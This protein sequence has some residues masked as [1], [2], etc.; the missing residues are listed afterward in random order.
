MSPVPN[1]SKPPTPSEFAVIA[2]VLSGALITVGL[3]G[4]GF[5]LFA[6]P[7]KHEAAAT[8]IHL[9]GWAVGLGAFIGVAFWTVRRFTD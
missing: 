6:P 8:L 7:Q 3:I 1:L 4:F 9:S 2:V 5:S